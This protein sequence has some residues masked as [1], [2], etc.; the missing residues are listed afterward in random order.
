MSLFE[1]QYAKDYI[2]DKWEC[3]TLEEIA[4]HLCVNYT[5]VARVAKKIGLKSRRERQKHEVQN[6]RSQLLQDY[7]KKFKKYPFDEINDHML[8]FK[9]DRR[10]AENDFL[11]LDL[12]I[13]KLQ[14]R[15]E[16]I[17]FIE[18]NW[19]DINI[20]TIA[21]ILNVHR[22]TVS[23]LAK[24]IGLPPKDRKGENNGRWKGGGKGQKAINNAI[25]HSKEGY[26]WKRDVKIRDDLTCQKCGRLGFR[27][28][29]YQIVAVTAHHIFNF[30]DY[31]KLRFDVNNGIT[32]CHCCHDKFHKNLDTDILTMNR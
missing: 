15:N 31:P 30:Y 22:V 7:K 23:K 12:Y 27:N 17:D 2:V 25:R 21:K 13:P 32:F 11:Y 26:A 20:Q 9:V 4:N 8:L 1:N 10:T 6:R 19:E 3:N 18:E 16:R 14:I 24:E 29:Y 28:K 5:T